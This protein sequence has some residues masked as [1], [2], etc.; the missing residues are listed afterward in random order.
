ATGA[1]LG[2]AISDRPAGALLGG[3]AGAAAGA[4]VGSATARPQD[5]YYAP[6]RRCAEYY[7]DYNGRRV[8]RSFY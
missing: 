8:C 2:A 5:D 1:L 6:Q 3:V 7:Y 4:M